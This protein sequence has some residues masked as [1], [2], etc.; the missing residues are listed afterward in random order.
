MGNLFKNPN[1][2]SDM[3]RE[4]NKVAQVISTTPPSTSIPR[5]SLEELRKMNSHINSIDSHLDEIQRSAN[6]ESELQKKRFALS[7]VAEV[8]AAVAAV[9]AAVVSIILL[10]HS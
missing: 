6:E 9:I 10:I 1:S 7:I 8:V 4:L 5:D 3:Q 2:L